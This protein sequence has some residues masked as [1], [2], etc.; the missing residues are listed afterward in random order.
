MADDVEYAA[1]RVY[2][3]INDLYAGSGISERIEQLRE[4][5]STVTGVQMTFLLVEAIGLQ[6]QLLPWMHAFHIPSFYILGFATPE[7]PIPLPDLFRLVTPEFWS[8]TTLWA[9][10]SILVP[11]L[12]AYFYNLS[13]HDVKHHGARVTVSR[14]TADPLTFNV[15]K[16][17]MTLIVYQ[18]GHTFGLFDQSVATN[19]TEALYGG[20]R[21][22]LI[23]SYVGVV[24]AIYEAVQRK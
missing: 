13:T 18:A 24:A 10:T 6:R 2:A 3:G 16:G 23:S 4:L 19:V 15:V 1:D 7:I 12:F 8:T 17:L 9:T 11:L 22:M 14:Y 21:G 5:C 20:Y